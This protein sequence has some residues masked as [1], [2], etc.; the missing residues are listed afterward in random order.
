LYQLVLVV[1]HFERDLA[2][3][4][5]RFNYFCTASQFID[6][7]KR[8]PKPEVSNRHSFVSQLYIPLE[9]VQ[10]P[11]YGIHTLPP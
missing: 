4:R 9:Y 11:P 7:E 5:C 6:V 3:P 1:T 10:Q 2:K 8:P